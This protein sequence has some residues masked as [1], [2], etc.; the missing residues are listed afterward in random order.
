MAVFTVRRLAFVVGVCVYFLLVIIYVI[1]TNVQPTTDMTRNVFESIVIFIISSDGAFACGECPTI[2]QHKMFCALV[3][4]LTFPPLCT[5]RVVGDAL[6]HFAERR[7]SDTSV[8]RLLPSRRRS[9]VGS[10]KPCF[11]IGVS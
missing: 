6:L 1:F 3:R 9:S 11:C 10:G 4:R 5:C 7:F 8:L 2:K